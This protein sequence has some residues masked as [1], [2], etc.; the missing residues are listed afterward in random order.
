MARRRPKD[1]LEALYSIPFAIG[2]Y[3]V[4]GRVAPEH[5][6]AEGLADRRV[7][8]FADRVQLVAEDRFTG[9]FPEKCRQ[10]IHVRFKDGQDYNSGALSARGDPDKPFSDEELK[11][12]FAGLAEP[13]VGKRYRKIIDRI[14]SLENH[15]AADLVG[16]LWG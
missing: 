1:L 5:L 13:V 12:K 16:L 14:D 15:G 7:L 8:A 10:Q 11:A 6:T 2:C 9:E 4:H 3:L